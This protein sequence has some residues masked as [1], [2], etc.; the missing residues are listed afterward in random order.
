MKLIALILLT[1]F[2]LGNIMYIAFY[3]TLN[4][5]ELDKRAMEVLRKRGVAPEGGTRA[6]RSIMTYVIFVLIWPYVF[7]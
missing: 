4:D 7:I 3:D 6:G 2:I 5:P 1:Y